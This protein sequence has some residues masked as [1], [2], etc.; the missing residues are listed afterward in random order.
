[1]TQP[2]TKNQDEAKG[3]PPPASHADQ[4]AAEVEKLNGQVGEGDGKFSDGGL[5]QAEA[6]IDRN[7][8]KLNELARN[9]GGAR[10]GTRSAGGAISTAPTHNLIIAAARFLGSI[11]EYREHLE[12]QI[13]A[14]RILEDFTLGVV[15]PIAGD[16]ADLEVAMDRVIENE[17]PL[18]TAMRRASGFMDR[19]RHEG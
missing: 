13:E 11:S 19:F 15:K 2:K 4:V 18:Q 12:E 17:N 16:K 10:D 14:T 6:M 1:M 5:V 8:Q 7:V 9:V 3:A